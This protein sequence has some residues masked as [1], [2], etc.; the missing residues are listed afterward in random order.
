MTLSVLHS[1]TAEQSY[2]DWVEFVLEVNDTEPDD[3]IFLYPMTGGAPAGGGRIMVPASETVRVPRAILPSFV[4]FIGTKADNQKAYLA[5]NVDL[6]NDVKVTLTAVDETGGGAVA[7][8]G[9]QAHIA[10][11]V[12]IDGSPA[13][14]DV[15]VVSDNKSG[16][17]KVVGEGS[18]AGD[19]TFD[20]TYTDWDGAVIALALD[21][22]GQAFEAEGALN[23]GQVVHPTSPNGHVYE[24]TTAGTT[25]TTEP[26]WSTDSSV[27][28]GS[29]T[30]NPRPYYRPIASGPLEGEIIGFAP[31]YPVIS[32]YTTPPDYSDNRASVSRT[33]PDVEAG[34]LIIAYGLY[35]ASVTITSGYTFAPEPP[36]QPTSGEKQWTFI[37]YKT[38]DGTEGGSEFTIQNDGGIDQNL[39]LDIATIKSNQGAELEVQHI[40]STR[41][42][43]DP[44]ETPLSAV[45]SEG[46]KVLMFCATSWY[47]NPSNSGTDP[48]RAFD[49]STVDSI[50]PTLLEDQ[51]TGALGLRA[52]AFY[53]TAEPEESISFTI[54]TYA[55][56]S[57]GTRADI[58][59][60]IR[61]VEPD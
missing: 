54:D 49:D 22:Y 5:L 51:P 44:D 38:A 24:V 39:S 32:G 15:I 18:S 40:S 17:R 14:R 20:I 47:F 31:Q 46:Q 34:D 57:N 23:S 58:W 41:E 26:T 42:T 25:G 45:N 48:L 1:Q 55:D 27:Q 28:S 56:E 60:A 43:G 16:G 52:A 36:D 19:G 29:V 12:L 50:I 21:E 53:A 6:D 2:L 4:S 61:E 35:R 59:I 11:T 8:E 37:A 9:I 13:A 33:I 7:G 30:F 3:L 10:G